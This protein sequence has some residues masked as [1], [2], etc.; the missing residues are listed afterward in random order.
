MEFLIFLMAS[1]WG[2]GTPLPLARQGHEMTTAWWSRVQG[3]GPSVIPSRHPLQ[4]QAPL[5][6][7]VMACHSFR[8]DTEDALCLSENLIS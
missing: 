5:N 3:D 8:E 7:S 4:A 2:R 1:V 6:L